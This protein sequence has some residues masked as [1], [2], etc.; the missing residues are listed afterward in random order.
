VRLRPVDRQQGDETSVASEQ[1]RAQEPRGSRSRD[2]E[3]GEAREHPE[4]A[5]SIFDAP[6][7]CSM[8][9]ARPAASR[10]SSTSK[11]D[12]Q[13]SAFVLPGDPSRS[14]IVSRMGAPDDMRMP[15]LGTNRV[16]IA[17]RDLVAE[18]VASIEE[19]L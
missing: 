10:I 17:G 16:D 15:P 12:P 1:Q 7:G 2:A 6:R 11:I 3:S 14:V 19:C 4:G 5:E 9:P 8:L 18:W 13:G